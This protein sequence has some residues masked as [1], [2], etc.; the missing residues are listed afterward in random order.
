MLKNATVT[1]SLLHVVSSVCAIF[2]V[3]LTKF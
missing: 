1:A 3:S 2:E